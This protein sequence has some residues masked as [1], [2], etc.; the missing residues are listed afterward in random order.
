VKQDNPDFYEFLPGAPTPWDTTFSVVLS[1]T[2][3]MFKGTFSQPEGANTKVINSTQTVALPVPPPSEQIET[4]DLPGGGKS[5]RIW[6]KPR[7]GFS[8]ASQVH[9]AD[10]DIVVTSV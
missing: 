7:P 4:V 5:V 2:N 10:C 3:L 6:H 9:Q 8:S 1:D